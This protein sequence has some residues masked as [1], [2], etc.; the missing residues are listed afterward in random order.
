MLL[1]AKGAVA[2]H[3]N[4]RRVIQLTRRAYLTYGVA[5]GLLAPTSD[6]GAGKPFA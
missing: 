3:A 5:Y 4:S 1:V 2:D 6:R